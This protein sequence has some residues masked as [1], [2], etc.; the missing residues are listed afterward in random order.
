M[1]ILKEALITIIGSAIVS[2][3]FS[4]IIAL[5]LIISKEP[6]TT[7]QF[8]YMTLGLTIVFTV[9]VALSDVEIE[10]A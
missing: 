2:V 6:A 3:I 5:I 9:I 7:S 8:A 4:G 1:G 10:K